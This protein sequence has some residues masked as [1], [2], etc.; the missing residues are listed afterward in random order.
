MYE[1]IFES[2]HLCL[3]VDIIAKSHP[4]FLFDV[5]EVLV[6]DAAHEV[7]LAVGVGR[8]MDA[9]HC[10]KLIYISIQSS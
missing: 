1:L 2:V 6:A 5:L 8:Y 7:L 4:L 10:F 9:A 3:R